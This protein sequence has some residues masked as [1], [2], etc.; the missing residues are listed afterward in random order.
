MGI[1]E[2]ALSAI[3]DVIKRCSADTK[4]IKMCELGNQVVKCVKPRISAKQYFTSRGIEHI[5]FDINGADGAIKINLAEDIYKTHPKYVGYF[6]ILTNCG[7]TEH[8]AGGQFEVFK[9][10]HSLVRSGGYFYH[11][12]PCRT[13]GHWINHGFYRYSVEFF[14]LLSKECGYE[15]ITIKE[16]KQESNN[17]FA[18]MRKGNG[19]YLKEDV[20]TPLLCANDI[21]TE[22]TVVSGHTWTGKVC[23]T[24]HKSTGGE[25]MPPCKECVYCGFVAYPYL[26]PCRQKHDYSI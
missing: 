9:N 7:T 18:L 13:A 14:T 23:G 5:S 3:N 25:D 19:R 12:V 8:I 1:G 26:K 4:K 15:I 10:I 22:M 6:D 16:T 24:P 21:E 17:I 2:I 20:L 11:L